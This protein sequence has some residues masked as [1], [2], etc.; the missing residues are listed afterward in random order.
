[1]R[2]AH[3]GSAGFVTGLGFVLVALTA[4]TAHGAAQRTADR[5]RL[6][7]A[8]IKLDADGSAGLK[9]KYESALQI[10]EIKTALTEIQGGL[11]NGTPE[12]AIA[13][14]DELIA[15]KKPT[16]EGLQ[17]ILYLKSLVKFRSG[18]KETAQKLLEEA[19]AAAPESK[20]AA[21]IDEVLKNVF[22]AGK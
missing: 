14:I 15:E 10:G 4:M 8:V 19:K 17:E 20:R 16:G 6:V 5:A 21:N 7:R 3:A 22:G 13:K 12:E 2:N 18:D 9:A 11:R 1:M